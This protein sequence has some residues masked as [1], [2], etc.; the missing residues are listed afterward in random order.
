MAKDTDQDEGDKMGKT[1]DRL[2]AELSKWGEQLTKLD[3]APS[4]KHVNVVAKS[5]HA[6]DWADEPRPYNWAE[7]TDV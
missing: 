7:E 1:W 5:G 4:A 2:L 6:Y 3:D